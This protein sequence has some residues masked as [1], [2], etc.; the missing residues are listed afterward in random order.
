M[1]PDRNDGVAPLDDRRRSETA[2]ETSSTAPDVRGGGLVTLPPASTLLQAVANGAEDLRRGGEPDIT[3]NRSHYNGVV[4]HHNAGPHANAALY[5]DGAFSQSDPRSADGSQASNATTVPDQ[6]FTPTHAN[7]PGLPSSS[8]PTESTGPDS[9]LLQL[10]ELAA[11]QQRMRA[12]SLARKR[13]ADGLVKS[14]V[15]G[16][17]RT[18]S[19]VSA[20]STTSTIGEVSVVF[21]DV[22]VVQY[23][24]QFAIDGVKFE[25]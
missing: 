10:S 2:T 16:H 24:D 4:R 14:P 13:T 17:S 18:T 19:A 11:G 23:T 9:Q 25:E 12:D 8:A 1:A 20:L 7:G 6:V 22:F 3:H 21:S 15:R 5:T